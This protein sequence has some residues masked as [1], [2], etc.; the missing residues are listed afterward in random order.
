MKKGWFGKAEEEFEWEKWVINVNIQFAKSES[1]HSLFQSG[2]KEQLTNCL[3]YISSL[4][5]ENKNHIPPITSQDG[6]P[7][8]FKVKQEIHAKITIPGISNE[9]WAKLLK[10]MITE[11]PP[12]LQ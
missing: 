5:C 3:F 1:E 10:K 2:L 12:V 11:T 8:P 7:F 4:C 6:N 9:S